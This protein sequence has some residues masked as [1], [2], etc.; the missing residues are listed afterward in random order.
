[1]PDY[2]FQS[3]S[4]IDFQT[5]ARDLLQRHLGITLESFGPGKDAGIDFRLRDTSGQ[6]V[7]Q[8]KHYKD[9]AV[10][11]RSLKKTEVSKVHK[12][13]PARYILT[14]SVSLTP[15]RKDELLE[16][17]APYCRCSG[18]IFGRE[19]LNNLLGSY[20]EIERKN[21]KLWLTS[22]AVLEKFINA[23]IW[24]DS[25]LTVERLKRRACLYVSNPSRGRAR[26]ILDEHHYCIVAG[27]PGIGK[28]TLA[29]ILLIEYVDRYDYQAVRISNDLS[30]IKGVKDPARKQIFYFDDFLGTTGLDK[31]QKNED[32]RL[33]E[34][35]DE[36]KSNNNWRFVLTTR[37]YILNSAKLRYES[38]S[39]PSADITPCII[40]LSDYTEPIRAK[41]LYNHIYFSDLAD[42][43]K[44]ALL[45]GKRYEQIIAHQNYNP[46]II[47][48]MT[49][50]I[51][52]KN[53]PPSKFFDTFLANLI[54]PTMIWDHAF[55]YQLS[56]AAQ[57]LLL[58]MGTLGDEV[59][60]SDLETAF[61]S[62]YNYRQIKLGFTIRTRD[63]DSAVKELDGNF[64]KTGMIGKDRI[65]TLHNP[66]VS[67]FL[68]HYF[69]KTPGDLMELIRSAYFFDQFVQ[70]WAGRR[71]KRYSAFQGTGGDQFL[72]A[73]GSDVM[74]PCF[75]FH[76]FK[77][78][79]M[80]GYYGVRVEPMS[81]EHRV[82]FVIEVGSVVK[83]PAAVELRSELLKRLQSLLQANQG[84]SSHLVSLL[85]KVAAIEKN[86]D[87]LDSLLQSAKTNLLANVDDADLEAFE[88]LGKFIV[89]FPQVVDHKELEEVRDRFLK[90]S[91]EYD[92]SWADSPDD[93]RYISQS[94]GAS[95]GMLSVDISERCNDLE[96]RAS[97]WDDELSAREPEEYEREDDDYGRHG[98]IED[99]SAMFEDLL[100]ELD[101]RS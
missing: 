8:C 91:N 99:T 64:I 46:R 49:Q 56:D 83:T 97:L 92:E 81:F 3:L 34:F 96:T 27:I 85:G 18:D 33:L 37:E 42:S 38:F 55:R 75:K 47:E 95:A 54:N 32:K 40:E 24:N 12:I 39:Q 13:K 16:L 17:F 72:Q 26:Q 41:I 86:K 100:N 73:I 29:E 57:H 25:A 36:V 59:R 58:V 80:D 60:F 30:E 94:L 90:F 45:E 6:V 11:L 62:F 61:N 15:A 66:S 71:G 78:G 31:L 23:A 51:R 5:L 4:S 52:I 93:Y 89:E 79:K 74:R 43:Y 19:D 68:E 10:L 70:L 2:D 65:V 88:A 7:V 69:E 35:M 98:G 63:F 22:A 82:A 77:I 76:R 20:P 87:R 50:A 53:V 14:L 1:M 101:E 48:Y 84:N 21:T 44:R 28:T 67:D 9:Y